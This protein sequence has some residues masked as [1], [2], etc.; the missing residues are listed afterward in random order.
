VQAAFADPPLTRSAE[1]YLKA[2]YHISNQGRVAT[3]SDIAEMLEV[4]PPSVSGMVKRLAAMGLIDH[5]PY[6][7][8]ELTRVGRRAALRMIRRHRILE[9]YLNQQLGYD[10]DEVHLEA[11]R[12]EHAVTDKLIE[13]MAAVLGDPQYDPHGDPIPSATGETDQAQLIPLEE[14]EVGTTVELRQVATQ[15][16]ARLRFLAEQG[17]TLGVLLHVTDRQ[18]FHGPTSIALVPSGQQRV[19][20]SELARLIGCRDYPVEGHEQPGR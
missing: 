14:V 3:T 6:H 5:T 15:D 2:I 16:S 13:R 17:L 12:L 20:G 11:E 8:V 9:L 4:A 10:W 7:G 19:I 18:P 1:D